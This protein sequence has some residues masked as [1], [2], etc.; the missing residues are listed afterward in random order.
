MSEGTA[1][2]LV[3]A[4]VAFGIGWTAFSLTWLKREDFTTSRFLLRIGSA[5]PQL[6]TLFVLLA[7]VLACDAMPSVDKWTVLSVVVG[8]YL[9]GHAQWPIEKP[10]HDGVP[11]YNRGR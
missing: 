7:F 11:A 5:C 8:M 2:L 3:F 6:N 10:P 4:L 9:L 1:R